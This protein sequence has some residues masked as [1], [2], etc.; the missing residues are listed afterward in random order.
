MAIVFVSD[1]GEMTCRKGV[2][3]VYNKLYHVQELILSARDETSIR[4]R[5]HV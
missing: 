4:L 2:C 3:A 5:L 1:Q